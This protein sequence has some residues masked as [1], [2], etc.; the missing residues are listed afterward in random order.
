[1][2]YSEAADYLSKNMDRLSPSSAVRNCTRG[3]DKDLVGRKTDEMLAQKNILESKITI[4]IHNVKTSQLQ[5]QNICPSK[6]FWRA[7]VL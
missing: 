2:C 6:Q 1:M 7:M 4:L 5:G 3:W